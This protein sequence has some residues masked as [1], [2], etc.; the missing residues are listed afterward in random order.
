M[1][2]NARSRWAAAQADRAGRSCGVWQVLGY[3]E[4]Q[5]L[6]GD[7]TSS[8]AVPPCIT[9]ARAS[10]SLVDANDGW[11]YATP[12]TGVPVVDGKGAV[13]G[14]KRFKSSTAT[15]PRPP[16]CWASSAG[17][18][19]KAGQH[20]DYATLSGRG[21]RLNFERTEQEQ[22]WSAG[23]SLTSRQVAEAFGLSP[24]PSA[25]SPRRPA[26]HAWSGSS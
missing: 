21:Q 10:P 15:A 5:T 16:M 2:C 19:G 26:R 20:I 24:P 4:R 18:W 25:K 8:G 17:A 9:P 23:E 7:D 13:L 6:G 22:V 12:I 1:A 3:A 11:S 14:G